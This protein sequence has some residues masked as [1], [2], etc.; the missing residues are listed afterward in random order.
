MRKLLMTLAARF[1]LRRLLT[2]DQNNRL[3]KVLEE[4]EKNFGNSRA[5]FVYVHWHVKQFVT[6]DY[7][8]YKIDFAIELG[9][10]L[11]RLHSTDK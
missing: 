3:K 4:A 1:L 11:K 8:A 9:V 2:N 7:P 10:F 5:K 6:K